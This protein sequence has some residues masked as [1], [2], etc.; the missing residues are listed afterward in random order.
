MKIDWGI[1]ANQKPTKPIQ[2]NE[3]EIG[4]SVKLTIEDM[5]QPVSDGIDYIVA[6]VSST[7]IEGDTMWLKG[8]FGL[9][10]GAFSL[11][12]L[13]GSDESEDFVG[14][15]YIVSKVESEKSL[16]GYA[17]RWELAE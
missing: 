7:E 10:N 12:K 17:Y 11:F 15:D 13:I 6:T 1:E 14:K 3:L 5:R 16:T 9:K 8:K 4:E 2:L